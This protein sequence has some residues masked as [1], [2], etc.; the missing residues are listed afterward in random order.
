MSD[1][2]GNLIVIGAIVLVVAL[3]FFGVMIERL[4]STC[5]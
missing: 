4:S 1:D 3:I 2:R 5:P